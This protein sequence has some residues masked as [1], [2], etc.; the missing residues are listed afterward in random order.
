M[1]GES[2]GLQGYGAIDEGAGGGFNPRA[3][4][5][6]VLLCLGAFLINVHLGGRFGELQNKLS[7]AIFDIGRQSECC[8]SMWP[9]ACRNCTY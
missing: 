4:G 6:F 8:I 5:T 2:S 9:N 7:R 1:L 3:S